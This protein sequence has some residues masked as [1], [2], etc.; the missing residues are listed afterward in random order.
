MGFSCI[1]NAPDAFSGQSM[2][3]EQ[4]LLPVGGWMER[5]EVVFSLRSGDAVVR[6]VSNMPGVLYEQSIP[7]GDEVTPDRPIAKAE[8]DG[9]EIPYGRPYVS[10]EP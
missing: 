10:E 8:V 3:L 6:F 1:I 7:A 5:G 9:D 4:W 2:I